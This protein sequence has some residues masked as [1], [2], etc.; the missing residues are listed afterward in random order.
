M[1]LATLRARKAL[2]MV[3]DPA[4]RRAIRLGVAPSIEHGAVP[5]LDS[6][7]TII[8]AG[9]ARGQFALFARKRYPKARV[10]CFE[11]LREARETLQR[12][13]QSDP[14]VEVYGVA[15][16]ARS[17]AATLN[18]SAQ[19]DSSS[20]LPIGANQEH[21]YPGT[22][23]ASEQTVTVQRLDEAL[24][25]VASPALI[26]VD[27]QGGELELFRGAGEI[28]SLFNDIFVECSFVELYDG[29]PLAADV[30]GFLFSHRFQL[31]GVYGVARA[32][33]GICLQ[34]DFLLRRSDNP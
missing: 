29:Q 13:F 11:P 6:Y 34:A 8:D 14:L 2:A 27:V 30:L 31:V 26:K 9:A 20:L 23:K 28:L 12:L 32:A 4:Y 24:D 10:L 1:P 15:L 7:E 3:S 22:G 25:G 17:G 18:V 5:F 33:N 19:D 16:G 21:I